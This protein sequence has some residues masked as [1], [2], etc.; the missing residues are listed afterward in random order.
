MVAGLIRLVAP[1]AKIL[2]L[3]AFRA[4]GSSTTSNIIRAIYYAVEKGARVINVSFSAWRAR[5]SSSA[6][7]PIATSRGVICVAAAGNTGT[8]TL[9]YPAALRA[10]SGWRPRRFRTPARCFPASALPW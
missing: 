3:K 2:P 6:R 9:T 1:E 5:R 7:S 10:Y 8:N 4:D